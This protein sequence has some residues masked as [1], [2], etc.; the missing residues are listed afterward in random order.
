MDYF[1]GKYTR[2]L[3]LDLGYKYVMGWEI[4]ERRERQREI[5]GKS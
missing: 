4:R 2:V 3:A 1:W 5:M